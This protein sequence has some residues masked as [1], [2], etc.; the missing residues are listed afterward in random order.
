[1]SRIIVTVSEVRLANAK[2]IAGVKPDFSRQ[3]LAVQKVVNEMK[4]TLPD[5]IA[6][7][8]RQALHAYKT[9]IRHA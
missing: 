5:R 7:A 6:E 4:Q 3:P 2:L 8:G 1:M 9:P